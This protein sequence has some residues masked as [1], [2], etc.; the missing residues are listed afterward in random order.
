M[1]HTTEVQLNR[2][3]LLRILSLS[4]VFLAIG[5]YLFQLDAEGIES[6]RRYNVPIVVHGI[7]LAGIAIFGLSIARVLPKL[8][9]H[10]PG[11]VLDAHGLT[12]NSSASSCGFVPWS[13]IS[14]LEERKIYNQRVLYVLL[15]DR[16]QYIASHGPLKRVTLEIM[17][18]SAPSPVAILA[19]S[20][21]IGF[22]DLVALISGYLQAAQRLD[23]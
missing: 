22:D 15:R 2:T 9:D 14:G 10:T 5:I 16:D 17:K 21:V 20:L 13:E 7:A 1:T 6:W 11:L 12:D 23:A 3:N 4:A 19:D 8:F 18:P